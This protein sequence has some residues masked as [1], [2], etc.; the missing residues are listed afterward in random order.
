MLGLQSPNDVPLKRQ[1]TQ[2]PVRPLG[3]HVHHHVLSADFQLEEIAWMQP[4]GHWQPGAELRGEVL[5]VRPTSWG[6][7]HQEHCEDSTGAVQ[8]VGCRCPP[9]PGLPSPPGLAAPGCSLFH[10][11]PAD[12]WGGSQTRVAFIRSNVKIHLVRFANQCPLDPINHAG[13]RQ[14]PPSTQLLGPSSPYLGL[15]PFLQAQ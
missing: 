15:L 3:S 5:G 7:Q 6:E 9:L 8:A 2:L 13:K 1:C 12:A 4:Q 11:S 10:M 14:L